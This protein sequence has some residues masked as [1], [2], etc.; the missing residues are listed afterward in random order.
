MNMRF[1]LWWLF[2]SPWTQKFGIFKT[3]QRLYFAN[4]NISKR[5]E[6]QL[7]ILVSIKDRQEVLKNVFISSVLNLE[8]LYQTALTIVCHENEK[9][10]I[11]LTTSA[12]SKHIEVKIV[13]VKTPFARAKYLNEGLKHLINKWVFITDVDIA[14]PQN[15]HSIFNKFVN[16]Q[17]AWFPI[18]DLQN[19][20]GKLDKQYP[21]GV[22]LVGYLHN[23]NLSF[24]EEIKEWGNEDWEFLYLLFESG[25]YPE[26]S[27]KDG[28]THYFHAPVSKLNYKK[29]W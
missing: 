17:R 5:G 9:E 7:H 24:N 20:Q 3:M 13:T 1:R 25:M 22:G 12:L 26:R 29:S 19:E 14:V 23:K 15:L 4:R 6:K 21:E 28:F 18:C 2:K 10:E 27:Q 11:T 8:K 16:A